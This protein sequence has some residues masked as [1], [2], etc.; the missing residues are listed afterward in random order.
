MPPN[1]GKDESAIKFCLN[2][3]HYTHA[4]SAKIIHQPKF[5]NIVLFPSSLHHRTIPFQQIQIE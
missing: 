4:N 1:L 3:E 2:G 5:G